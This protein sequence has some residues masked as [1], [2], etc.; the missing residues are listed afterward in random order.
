MAKKAAAV[1]VEGLKILGVAVDPPGWSKAGMPV[2][3]RDK[4]LQAA[5]LQAE[6]EEM[7]EDLK[8]LKTDIKE[9]QVANGEKAII[10]GE[11]RCSVYEG[12]SVTLN[13]QKLLEHGVSV[14][15]IQKSTV[16]T[17]YVACRIT[18]IKE[19]RNEG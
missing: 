18:P 10:V 19:D 17:E 11:F 3:W 13:K 12:K 1:V 16:V 4:V 2:S 8:A 14:E 5:A 7:Q 6:I 9:A 15:V